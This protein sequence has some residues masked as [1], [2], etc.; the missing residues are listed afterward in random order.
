M[1]ENTKFDS[2]NENGTTMPPN[3]RY[4]SLVLGPELFMPGTVIMGELER[5]FD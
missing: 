5:T 3:R 1:A 2:M 4:G